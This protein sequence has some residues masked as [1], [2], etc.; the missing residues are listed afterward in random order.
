MGRDLQENW[1]QRKST[2]ELSEAKKWWWGILAPKRI[3]GLVCHDV[4]SWKYGVGFGGFGAK[5]LGFARVR[6]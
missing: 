5:W 2:N 4:E 1:Y 3:V 6:L